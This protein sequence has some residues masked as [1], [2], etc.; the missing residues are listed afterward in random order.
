[1]SRLFLVFVVVAPMAV[2]PALAQESQMGP[3]KLEVTAIPAGGTFFIDRKSEPGFGSYDVGGSLT[4]RLA[5]HVAVEGELGGRIGVRQS[6]VLG[7]TVTDL[8]T[9]NM[10]GYTGNLVVM[11][12]PRN[13][14]TPYVTAGVGGT[15][16][17]DRPSLGIDRRVNLLTGNVGGGVKWYA[18]HRWGLRGDYRFITVGAADDG[19]SFFGHDTRY[20]H[21]I[22]G[23]AVI[24]V[25]Q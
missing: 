12:P 13:S 11:G 16:V 6:L 24:N 19:P 15:T 5:R 9:P 22:Y 8:K 3:G 25:W 10:F 2:A 17:F 14:L 1:M 21:R 7:G 20:G 23:A 18:T 4:Y